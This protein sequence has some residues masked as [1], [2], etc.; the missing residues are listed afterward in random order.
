MPFYLSVLNQIPKCNLNQ[1]HLQVGSNCT[2]PDHFGLRTR[3]LSILLL[4]NVHISIDIKQTV[5]NV[6]LTKRAFFIYERCA[7]W[8][9]ESRNINNGDVLDDHMY[10]LFYQTKRNDTETH[11]L[12]IKAVQSSLNS[13]QEQPFMANI[14]YRIGSLFVVWAHK[15]TDLFMANTAVFLQL[16]CFTAVLLQCYWTQETSLYL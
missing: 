5:V 2:W 3:F 15:L 4:V 1:W 13:T 10:T 8:P 11:L 9:L 14:H 7:R 12:G 16:Y 6:W